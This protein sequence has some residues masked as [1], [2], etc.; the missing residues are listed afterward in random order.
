MKLRWMGAARGAA[1][2]IML[3]FLPGYAGAQIASAAQAR[4]SDAAPTKSGNLLSLDDLDRVAQVADPDFS[5]DGEYVVY[6]VS[7]NNNAEDASQSDLWRV[8]WDGTDRHPLTQT[9]SD[10]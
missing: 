10:S 6:S 4:A 1:A 9:N 5:P 7:V 8:R 3:V 2:A